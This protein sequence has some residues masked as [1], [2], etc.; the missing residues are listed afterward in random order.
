MRV[1]IR[2]MN[3]SALQTVYDCLSKWQIPGCIICINLVITMSDL[4]YFNGFWLV[5]V[6]F[7][8]N[9]YLF[10]GTNYP[11]GLFVRLHNRNLP[12]QF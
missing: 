5:D 3:L 7:L 2:Y 8:L 1:L 4:V 6:Y 10:N 12:M 9:P 11:F